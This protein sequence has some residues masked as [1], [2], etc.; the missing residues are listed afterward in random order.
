LRPRN[1]PL[2]ILPLLLISLS[3][4]GQSSRKE[5][6]TTCAT[7]HEEQALSQPA[8]QMAHAMELPKSNHVLA[9]HA[10]LTFRKDE[11]T[12][13]V[14]TRNGHSVYV[15]SDGAQTLSVPIVWSMGAQAQTWVLERNGKLY[16][17]RVSYYPSI[18][19]LDITTGDERLTPQNIDEAVGRPIAMDEA[20]A[21]FNCHAT[22]AVVGHQ[23]DLK[24]LHPGLTCERCHAGV[25]AHAA[26]MIAGSASAP[27][28]QSLGKLTSEDIS[29][30]CGQCHRSWE[31]VVRGHWRGQADV[32]FQPYRLANSRCF[33]GADPRISCVACHDPHQQVVRDISYYDA[34]CLVCHGPASTAA[35]TSTSHPKACPVAK[36][37]C[38]TCHMPQVSL[39]NGLL[40]F[41]DHQIR[42]VKP[43]ERYPD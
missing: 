6:R 17:S 18:N 7:C 33:N 41:T 26:G 11:Y 8:T 3:M 42:V 43:D 35:D 16:E 30:F 32:R 12:Y 15:V 27:I 34:K 24:A 31:T 5:Q 21:C 28:P 1:L 14:V 23:L 37:K 25:D 19:R 39:P 38:A 22:N 13:S 9:A 10:R 4:P 2:S 29:N 20:K 36:S 40:R